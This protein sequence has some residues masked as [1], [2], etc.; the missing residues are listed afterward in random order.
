MSDLASENHNELLK[1]HGYISKLIRL[2][3]KYMFGKKVLHY[4]T[5]KVKVIE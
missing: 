5:D 4:L 1:I 3:N 2:T